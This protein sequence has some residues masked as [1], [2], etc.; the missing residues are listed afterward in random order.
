M[1]QLPLTS[2]EAVKLYQKDPPHWLKQWQIEDDD[3]FDYL[4]RAL[5]E[6]ESMPN[7]CDVWEKLSQRKRDYLVIMVA[8]GIKLGHISPRCGSLV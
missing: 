7:V 3:A 1:D 2:S 6:L 5:R 4:C 8:A